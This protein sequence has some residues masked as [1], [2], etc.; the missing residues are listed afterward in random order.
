MH[1]THQAWYSPRLGHD[2]GIAVFGHWGPPLLAFP[3]S[4]GDEWELQR[5]G[6]IDAIGDL[7]EAGRVKVFCVGSNNHESFLNGGAHPLHRSW[8][9]RMFDEYIRDE[10]IPYIYDSCQTPGIPIGTMGPSL[11]AYHAANTL[12]RYPHLVKR[13]YGLSGIY[14]LRNFMGGMYDDNFYF[15]NPIDYMAGLNDPWF[16][17]QLLTCEIR[18][19]T[20]SGPHE[21]SGYSYAMSAVLERKG[22][23][24]HLDDWGHRGGHDWPYWK[25]QLREYVSRW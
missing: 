8:R 17:E 5:Q 25:E 24:H 10:V 12:F 18:L 4:Q 19:V 3:T 14:D 22:I 21:Q 6:M 16:L 13:C 23:R 2:M 15:Q 1:T 11:G 7:V 9:Q 20:G